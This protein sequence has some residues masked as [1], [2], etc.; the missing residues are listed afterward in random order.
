[1]VTGSPFKCLVRE[2]SSDHVNILGD[3]LISFQAGKP[4]YLQVLAPG[5]Q[6]DEVK[7]NIISALSC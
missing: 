2:A 1:M 6:K 4:A 5:F 7:L 3:A